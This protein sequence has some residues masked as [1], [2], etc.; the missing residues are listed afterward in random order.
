M[1]SAAL[2]Q[3]QQN[4]TRGLTATHASLSDPPRC[5]RKAVF[6]FATCYL[7]KA[8]IPPISRYLFPKRRASLPEYTQRQWDMRIVSALYSTFICIIALGII[9]NDPERT[10]MTNFHRRLW[11][12][13]KSIGAI[14]DYS[15]GYY[16]WELFLEL[17]NIRSASRD[18]LLHSMLTLVLLSL[19]YVRVQYCHN[20]E[21]LL[22]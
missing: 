3:L 11:G 7:L 12:Y 1:Q 10:H 13:S 21:T 4:E 5:I 16:L 18:T 6:M 9:A 2:E 15:L 22:C 19:C 8:V 20:S 14:G 17:Q